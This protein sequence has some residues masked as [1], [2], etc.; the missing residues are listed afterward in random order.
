MEYIECT[1]YRKYQ[2]RFYIELFI[3]TVSLVYLSVLFYYYSFCCDG[4]YLFLTLSVLYIIYLIIRHFQDG[5]KRKIKNKNK[6]IA[7]NVVVGLMV[8]NTF[9]Y[10]LVRH[11]C[12]T[13]RQT[14][15]LFSR[16]LLGVV[17]V[18]VSL[19]CFVQFCR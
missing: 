2:S 5:C 3:L 10:L 19:N 16:V 12:S 17:L 4:S 14:N 6:T 13:F 1:R 9:Y 15:P 18:L 11:D 8:V 7:T